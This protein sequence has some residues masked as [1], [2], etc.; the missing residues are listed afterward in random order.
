M[1]GTSQGNMAAVGSPMG[2]S[3]DAPAGAGVVV[4][5]PVSATPD[6]IATSID[7]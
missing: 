1:N 2:A 4:L 7:R 5:P 6:S 3:P